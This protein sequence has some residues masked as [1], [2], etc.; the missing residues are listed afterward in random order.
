MMNFAQIPILSSRNLISRVNLVQNILSGT[1]SSGSHTW[2]YSSTPVD[3]NLLVIYLGVNG[4]RTVTATGWTKLFNTYDATSFQTHV[5]AY[6]IASSEPANYTFTCSGSPNWGSSSV[7]LS[8][9][10]T[11]SNIYWN[12][13]TVGSG[14]SGNWNATSQDI[15]EGSFT[16]AAIRGSGG[17]IGVIGD[18]TFD[19]G[20]FDST[21][22]SI[23]TAF[24]SA[25][26]LNLNYD[27]A[28]STLS[29]TWLT[30]RDYVKC[31]YNVKA[32]PNG[33]LT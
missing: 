27:N 4:N 30:S 24:V 17:I 16:M 22:Y 8:N 2:S 23:N 10:D 18:I 26:K 6:K 12:E 11:S 33:P 3:G 7:E 32:N 25:Y 13:P 19:D 29:A 5:L 15:K 28:A 31:W 21:K 1:T 9:F 20:D 14:T